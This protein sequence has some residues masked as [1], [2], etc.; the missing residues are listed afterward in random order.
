MPVQASSKIQGCMMS[1]VR[2]VRAGN[3]SCLLLVGRGGQLVLVKV[4]ALGN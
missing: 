4:L 2:T 3:H 1:V